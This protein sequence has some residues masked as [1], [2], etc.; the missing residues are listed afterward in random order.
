M[1]QFKH[2]H[3]DGCATAHIVTTSTT[4]YESQSVL[5]CQRS[6]TFGAPWQH[7][8]D[9][10]SIRAHQPIAVQHTST[11]IIWNVFCISRLH[12][13]LSYCGICGIIPS[14]FPC[15]HR[16]FMTMKRLQ[17]EDKHWMLLQWTARLSKISTHCIPLFTCAF[18]KLPVE[19]RSSRST[20]E[21]P[22]SN[23]KRTFWRW[24][25]V[26][27]YITKRGTS[28]HVAALSLLGGATPER[29]TLK[30][31]TVRNRTEKLSFN[32]ILR[33]HGEVK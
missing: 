12:L 29:R 25:R 15:A 3:F 20:P 14:G 16:C 6:Q 9:I 17:M 22:C 32:S 23:R 19:Q 26:V 7:S 24:A 28:L 33:V 10:G 31:A 13:M 4:I 2:H 11:A 1:W 5:M 21:A 8:E 27:A 18:Y 30:D